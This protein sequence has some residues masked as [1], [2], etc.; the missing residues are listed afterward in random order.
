M[1]LRPPLG[2]RRIGDDLVD[3]ATFCPGPLTPLK[4]VRLFNAM[5]FFG[6]NFASQGSYLDTGRA[7]FW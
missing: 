1:S 6:K 4:K 5:P 3:P 2:K 7:L